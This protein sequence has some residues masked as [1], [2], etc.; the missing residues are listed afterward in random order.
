MFPL[1]LYWQ[2]LKLAYVIRNLV[3]IVQR[4]D[5]MNGDY[6]DAVS[7]SFLKYFYLRVLCTP[8]CKHHNNSI[9]ICQF[10]FIQFY[11]CSADKSEIVEA[12][13]RYKKWINLKEGVYFRY[14]NCEIWKT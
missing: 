6:M 13:F 5:I 14:S 8:F 3:S 10:M 12:I 2:N 7:I 1:S 9:K 4:I 11:S